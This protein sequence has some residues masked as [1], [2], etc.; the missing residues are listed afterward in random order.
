[1]VNQQ[2]SRPNGAERWEFLERQPTY[3]LKRCYQ[4]LRRTVEAE[5]R[6]YGITL[7]QRD[8]LLA[9]NYDGPMSQGELR[10]RLG[11]EQSSVSRLMDSLA[12]RG[13]VDLRADP[14]DRRT[15]IAAI[16]ATGTA[17]LLRTPGSS[18]LGGKG[19]VAGLSASEQS[20]L[21]RLLRHCTMNLE[22]EV[23]DSGYFGG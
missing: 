23:S 10:G 22:T 2:E 12:R 6:P 18:H 14:S 4:A 20:D 13:L 1:M 21:I 19:M 7:S 17:L 9:L 5:L 11:L 15:R 16:T 8:A 3:W